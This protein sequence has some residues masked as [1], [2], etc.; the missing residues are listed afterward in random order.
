MRNNRAYI[1]Q[2]EMGMKNH[3][4]VPAL[5]A[6]SIANLHHGG[7]HKILKDL[8]KHRLL[9]YE[10]GK[11]CKYFVYSVKLSFNNYIK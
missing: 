8:C 6:A 11:H 10:R 5:L 1:K 2:I 9:S 4:L 3:E 7:V